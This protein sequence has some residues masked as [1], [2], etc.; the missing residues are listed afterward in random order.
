MANITLVIVGI[1][2]IVGGYAPV[3]GLLVLAAMLIHE[4]Y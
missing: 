3:C 4:I 2:L 1:Y